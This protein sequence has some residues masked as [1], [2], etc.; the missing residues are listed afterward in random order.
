MPNNKGPSSQGYGF[1]SGQVQMWELDYNESWAPENWCF[2][3]VVLEKTLESPLGLQADPTRQSSRKSVLNIHWKD[4]D[5]Y[6]SSKYLDHLILRT[7]SLGKTLMLGKIEGRRRRRRQRMR[8]LDGITYRWT[9]VWVSSGSWWW[10]GKPGVFQSSELNWVPNLK[11]LRSLPIRAQSQTS[12]E[13]WGKQSK[14][15]VDW[16]ELKA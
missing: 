1:S 7:D 8:W 11:W 16:L 5:W 10:T 15:A 3:T 12:L 4:W 2:W 9:W 14:V 13:K 6:W